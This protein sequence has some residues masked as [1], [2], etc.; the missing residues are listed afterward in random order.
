MISLTFATAVGVKATGGALGV[1]SIFGVV[2]VA[3]FVS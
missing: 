3:M 2:M 1:V